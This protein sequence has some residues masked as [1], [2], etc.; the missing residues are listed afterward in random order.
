MSPSA[1]V[2]ALAA[3]WNQWW[4][5]D[6]FPFSP[7]CCINASRTG[8]EVL[9]QLGV[10]AKPLSVSIVVFNDF[11]WR[12]FQADKPTCEWPP[13]AWSIGV[14]T[15]Q[16]SRPGKW[17]GHL[18]IEGDGWMLDLSARQFHRPGRITVTEPWIIPPVEEE[19]HTTY[20]DDHRQ[21]LMI[22][23]TPRSNGWRRAPGWID[24]R[25]EVEQEL[26]RRTT[27]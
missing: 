6:G 15:G 22:A 11:A 21:V 17:N 2:A 13:Q 7:D 14:S 16:D 20:V 19:R 1:E 9:R 12:L 4:D 3:A 27:T 8:I 18:M 10:K 23:R 26:L 24:R 25:P 5:E